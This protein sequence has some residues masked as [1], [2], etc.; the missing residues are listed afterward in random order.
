MQILFKMLFVLCILQ[1][2]FEKF[3]CHLK[4]ISRSFQVQLKIA[5]VT[6]MVSNSEITWKLH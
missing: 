2:K 4:A 3:S 5:N 1:K 6:V